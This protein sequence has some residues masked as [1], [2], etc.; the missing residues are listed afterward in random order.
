M[1]VKER[2]IEYLKHRNIKHK[3][4]ND[5]IGVSKGYI[6]AISKSPSNKVLNRIT[7]LYPDLN[8]EWLV[9]GEGNM[10]RQTS[11]EPQKVAG[12]VE[13]PDAAY[14][15][16]RQQGEEKI[17][18][19]DKTNL[20]N[21][22]EMPFNDLIATIRYLSETVNNLQKKV[23]QLEYQNEKLRKNREGDQSLSEVG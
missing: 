10:L 16:Q 2:L 6:G 8:L 22:V 14:A 1:A 18:E 17:N 13:E 11:L 4:F 3:E 23:D 21:E 12:K 15:E 5:A 7:I 20:T 19:Q 9:T